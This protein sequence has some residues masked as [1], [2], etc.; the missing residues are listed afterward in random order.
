VSRRNLSVAPLEPEMRQRIQAQIDEYRARAAV[1][2]ELRD[3]FADLA[4][5]EDRVIDDY[6]RRI[7]DLQERLNREEA[8]LDA[9]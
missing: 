3:R 9:R 1:A 8:H 5:E 6:A 4:T 2:E 7:N